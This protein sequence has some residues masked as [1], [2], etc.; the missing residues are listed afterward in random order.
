MIDVTEVLPDLFWLHPP[1]GGEVYLVRTDAG[2]VLLDSGLYRHADDLLSGMTA[3]GL[4]PETIVLACATHFHCDHVGGLGWWR[5]RFGFEVVAHERAAG[6]M[7]EGDRIVTGAY[8][9]YCGFDEEFIPCPVDRKVEGGEVFELGGKFFEVIF[10]PGHTVGSIHI[11]CG[12]ALFAGDTL[13]GDGGIGWMDAHWGSNPGDCVETLRRMNA[14]FGHLVCPGHGEPYEL[15]G[16]IL[17]RGKE[18]AAFYIPLSH[19]LGAPRA[20]SGYDAGESAREK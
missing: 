10:A 12:K 11:R 1:D 8:L 9:P 17:A 13:F 19:G 4:D 2:L 15:T 14:A 5:E 18:I 16:E 20:P 3:A 7:E 6:P